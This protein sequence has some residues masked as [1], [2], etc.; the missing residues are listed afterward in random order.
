[1]N[2]IKDAC[3]KLKI[4][5]NHWLQHIVHVVV[6]ALELE[7]YVKRH[8][9]IDGLSIVFLTHSGIHSIMESL[10]WALK[11]EIPCSTNGVQVRVH[12]SPG[13]GSNAS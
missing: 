8:C 5:S 13:V 2:V 3:R 9:V 11:K 10:L 1:M 12:H 6:G 4:S 7:K